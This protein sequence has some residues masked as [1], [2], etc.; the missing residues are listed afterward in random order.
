M[1]KVEK[2]VAIGFTVIILTAACWMGLGVVEF[3]S[4]AATILGLF[5]GAS[6]GGAV[7]ISGFT[8]Y[9][10]RHAGGWLLVFEGLLP[11]SLAVST[12]TFSPL[13]AL[14]ISAPLILAGILFILD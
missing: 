1:D 5:K 10:W 6:I 8:A 14:I 2:R 13:A 4:K 9:R 11:I 12:N 3:F 7:L